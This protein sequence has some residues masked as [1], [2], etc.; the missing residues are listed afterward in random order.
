MTERSLV[1]S[2]AVLLAGV[3]SL[4]ACAGGELSAEESR[5]AVV[6]AC[7]TQQGIGWLKREYGERYCECYADTALEVLSEENY[8][9]LARASRAELDAADVADRERIAR[10]NTSVYSSVSGAMGSCGDAE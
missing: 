6:E 8:D 4:A 3:L 7:E 1:G 10:E 2:T 5:S 9:V